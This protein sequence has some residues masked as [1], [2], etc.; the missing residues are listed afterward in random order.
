M[1]WF[2]PIKVK[3]VSLTEEQAQIIVRNIA[4]V[5]KIRD[6]MELYRQAGYQL[7]A[8]T[9]DKRWLGQV[10]FINTLEAEMDKL[11][12]VKETTEPDNGYQSE[13]G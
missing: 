6:W 13:V 8:K 5:D 12:E 11:N 9:D 2:K 7:Y 1:K 3:M 4:R 10:D